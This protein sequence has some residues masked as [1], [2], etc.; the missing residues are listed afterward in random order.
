MILLEPANTILFNSLEDSA[1][2]H[3]ING[4]SETCPWPRRGGLIGKA[5][6]RHFITSVV[7]DPRTIGLAPSPQRTRAFFLPSQSMPQRP[8]VGSV[9][10][11]FARR[12]TRLT[13]N[14]LFEPPA[15]I[16]TGF[17][18]IVGEEIC[19]GGAS[20]GISG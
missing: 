14:Q 7:V 5:T 19:E 2:D 18:D 8:V 12:K 6:L 20:R 4:L 13:L 9:L 15:K 16:A 11:W 17:T 10:G 1:A 3:L